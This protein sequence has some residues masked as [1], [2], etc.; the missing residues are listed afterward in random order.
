MRIGGARMIRIGARSAQPRQ[1][2]GL[3]E[4]GLRAVRA[5]IGRED[6][7]LG[8]DADHQARCACQRAQG[9]FERTFLQFEVDRDASRF[10]AETNHSAA[11]ES[12][13]LRGHIQHAH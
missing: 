9:A 5:H 1:L 11:R 12:C 2:R 13:D 6:D 10:V 4:L 8:V 7:L 3:V